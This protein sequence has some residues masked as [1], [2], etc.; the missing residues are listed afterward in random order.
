MKH[1]LIACLACFILVICC[2]GCAQTSADASSAIPPSSSA[3]LSSESSAASEAPVPQPTIPQDYAREDFLVYWSDEVLFLPQSEDF[4]LTERY[5][6]GSES[7]TS[8]QL[9][10]GEARPVEKQ[11]VYHVT[12]IH[13]FDSNGKLIAERERYIFQTD[14]TV[15]RDVYLQDMKDREGYVNVKQV[16]QAIYAEVSPDHLDTSMTKQQMVDDLAA[17]EEKYYM[18]KPIKAGA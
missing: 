7:Y 10:E 4:L 15:P 12:R 17:K 16:E 6:Q 14:W 5:W 2:A 1:N 8:T 11:I 9:M 18:S 13:E 3:A